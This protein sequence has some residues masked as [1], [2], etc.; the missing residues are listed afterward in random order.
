MTD[1][2]KQGQS[3]AGI[4]RRWLAIW[5]FIGLPWCLGLAH[6]AIAPPPPESEPSIKMALMEKRGRIDTIIVGDSRVLRV[7]GPA[8]AQRGWTYFN[9][10]MSGLSPEDLVMQLQKAMLVEPVERVIIGL[11]FE[12]MTEAFPFEFSR[13]HSERMFQD[14]EIVELIGK[15]NPLRSFR[16]QLDEALN[17]L[18]PIGAGR[19]TKWDVRSVPELIR[20]DGTAAYVQ[21]QREIALGTY[22]FKVNRDPAM[23][24]NE[25]DSEARYLAVGHLSPES[26][27]LFSRV[28]AQLRE[29]RVPT[30]L[31]E[32]GR[33]AAYQAMIDRDPVL[34]GLQ[35]EWRAF[36]RAQATDCIRFLDQPS[37]HAVY[38]ENDF[39]DAV[40]FIG[41]TEGRL[42]K[43][44]AGEMAGLEADCHSSP[45]E[46]G[47]TQ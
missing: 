6:L 11:S 42:T 39:F 24:F 37:L 10:G 2:V 18:L 29:R 14:P 47:N 34:Q 32:T 19:H 15:A 17:K 43:R 1:P 4:S 23:Y 27:Q 44:L 30:L 22:D 13:Y 46:G 38:D 45:A 8:F 25:E 12:N 3:S 20:P 5:L 33:T 7:G 21:I 31:F 16:P 35:S 26:K 9:L 28:L 36:F 40:H 41:P